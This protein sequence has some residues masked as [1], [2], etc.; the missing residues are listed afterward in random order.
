MRIVHQFGGN[1][2]Q[3]IRDCISA[4]VRLGDDVAGLEGLA[5]IVMMPQRPADNSSVSATAFAADSK[6]NQC[7][8][9]VSGPTPRLERLVLVRHHYCKTAVHMDTTV[10]GVQTHDDRIC[11]IAGY[12]GEDKLEVAIVIAR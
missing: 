8:F 9:E 10:R 5:L 11:V 3:R 6:W 12:V 7:C 1:D 2:N 4:D